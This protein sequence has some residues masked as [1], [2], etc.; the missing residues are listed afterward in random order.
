MFCP[1]PVAEHTCIHTNT[2]THAN[3]HHHHHTHTHTH[4]TTT[5]TGRADYFGALPNLAAR[6]CAMAKPGQVLVDGMGTSLLQVWPGKL[7]LSKDTPPHELPRYA[8]FLYNLR[9]CFIAWST[10]FVKF[11]LYGQHFLHGHSIFCK[12]FV[13]VCVVCMVS[14]VFV[15][16]VVSMCPP[17][18]SPPSHPQCS[19]T[20]M[21]MINH[22]HHPPTPN[23]QVHWYMAPQ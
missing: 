18:T 1:V 2:H 13:C 12:V 14:G 9:T 23:P 7:A 6:V 15:A 8:G 5:T 17:P 3:H 21:P 16:C 19:P 20:I 4:T 22:P 10:F 11:V